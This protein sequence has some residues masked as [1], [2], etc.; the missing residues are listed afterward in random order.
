M[1][2]TLSLLSATSAAVVAVLAC[3]AGDLMLPGN[4]RSVAI[5]VVTGNNQ[6]GA[7]GQ[8]LADSLVVRVSDSLSRPVAQLR[9]AFVVTAGG[10][11]VAPDTAVTGNDG[12]ASSRWTLGPI[13]GA[14]AVQA[15]VVGSDMVQATFAATSTG[16]GPAVTTTQITSVNPEPSFPTQLVTV[17]FTVASTVGV[18]AGTVTVTDGTSSCT[19]QAAVGQCSVASMTAGSE[20][21]TAT[22]LGSATFAPSS[23][24][25]PHQVV[26]AGTST[27]LSSSPNPSVKE[28]PVTFTATVTSTFTT[29][30]GSVQFVEGSCATPTQIWS[31]QS[32][33]GSGQGSFSTEELSVGTHFMLACYLGTGTFAP[34]ASQVRRQQVNDD[35]HM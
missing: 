3:S 31:T 28:Q 30:S 13:T 20:T 23:G 7:A 18:P 25:A 26:L 8:P 24:T 32:L 34:S 11:T 10:G 14:Q 12:R 16:S 35:E 22:Y 1:R 6:A 29:P 4:S 15:R 2:D 17:H 33:N 27:M 19:A 5:A 9:V 21:L